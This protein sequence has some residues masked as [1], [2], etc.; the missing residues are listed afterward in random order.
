MGSGTSKEPYAADEINLNNFMNKAVFG[1]VD[2]ISSVLNPQ[3]KKKDATFVFLGANFD[4]ESYT[5]R[6]NVDADG[7]LAVSLIREMGRPNERRG[8]TA[9]GLGFVPVSASGALEEYIASNSGNGPSLDKLK[10]QLK[11]AGADPYLIERH[12]PIFQLA[13]EKQ[14]PLL[15][16]SPDPKDIETLRKGGLQSL[17]PQ[18][19]DAYVTDPEGFISMTRDPKFKLYTDKSLLKDFVPSS[20]TLTEEQFKAEQANFFAERILVHEAGAS[21][22]AAWAASRPN[23]LVISITSIPDVR[24]MGGVNG[25]VGRV[26]GKLKNVELGEDAVTTILLNPSASVSY[27]ELLLLECCCIYFRHG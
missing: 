14:Y 24:F 5:A 10:D 25:R 20:E 22:A 26:Y 6:G 11:N 9:I 16:L 15:A 2:A 18:K 27:N 17:D 8:N 1:S 23:S 13:H 21:A 19:R 3:P 12:V 4:S 7:E